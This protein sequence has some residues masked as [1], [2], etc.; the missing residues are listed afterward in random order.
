MKV[1]RKMTEII[2]CDGLQ[3]IRSHGKHFYQ[4]LR[5][6]FCGVH[7]TKRQVKI[8][9]GCKHAMMCPDCKVIFFH[10]FTG[11]NCDLPAARYHPWYHADACREYDRTFGCHLPEFSRK[12]FIFQRQNKCQRNDVRGVCMVYDTVFRVLQLLHFQIHQMAWQF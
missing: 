11:C 1:F 4:N 8:F 9:P 2:R 5:R 6:F 10:Q 3:L 7:Q 12:H